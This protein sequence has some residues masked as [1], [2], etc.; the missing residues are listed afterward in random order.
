MKLDL[1][2]TDVVMPILSGNELASV[3]PLSART[4]PSCTCRLRRRRHLEP[5]RPERWRRADPEAVHKKNSADQDSRDTEPS[6]GNEM[7]TCRMTIPRINPQFRELE[8]QGARNTHPRHPYL[9]QDGH[10]RQIIGGM[11]MPEP[12]NE[13]SSRNPHR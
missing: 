3:W 10:C 11:S 12:R 6:D 5:R 13:S 1:L 8:W 4:C 7:A 9:D 2:L